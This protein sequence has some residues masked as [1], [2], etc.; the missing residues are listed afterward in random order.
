MLTNILIIFMP[1]WLNLLGIRTYR[2]LKKPYIFKLFFQL[3]IYRLFFSR[4]IFTT[5]YFQ[6]RDSHYSFNSMHFLPKQLN[7][8]VLHNFSV[9]S[10]FI[11]LTLYYSSYVSEILQACCKRN[12]I[13]FSF[14]SF[15]SYVHN[16]YK[17]DYYGIKTHT[18]IIYKR[19]TLCCS[20]NEKLCEVIIQGGPL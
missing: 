2:Y 6:A 15:Y 5:S 3:L 10:Q 1:I 9:K 8:I 17:R 7:E 18:T 19:K 16:P 20:Q 11:I 13:T 14:R 4:P 12:I